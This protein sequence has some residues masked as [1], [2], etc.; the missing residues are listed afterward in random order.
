MKLP[1]QLLGAAA[2]GPH[3]THAAAV[4][5]LAVGECVRDRVRI[6][7]AVRVGVGADEDRVLLE[8]HHRYLRRVFIL[9]LEGCIREGII[10]FNQIRLPLNF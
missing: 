4:P 9:L 5:V 1:R 2:I 6:C 10:N 3:I 7:V 8:L